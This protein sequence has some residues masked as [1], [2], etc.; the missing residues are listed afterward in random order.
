MSRDFYRTLD[1]FI[2]RCENFRFLLIEPPHDSPSNGIEL[3]FLRN[4]TTIQ[5]RDFDNVPTSDFAGAID[6][7]IAKSSAQNEPSSVT[8][9]LDDPYGGLAPAKLDKDKKVKEA[10]EMLK[11]QSARH[12]VDAGKKRPRVSLEMPQPSK[13]SKLLVASPEIN[14]ARLLS[15][16]DIL[17]L[18]GYQSGMANI[19]L[20]TEC[21]QMSVLGKSV[22]HATGVLL[23]QLA[24]VLRKYVV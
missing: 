23:V 1:Q 15:P 13:S 7:K 22:P 2:E 5:T 19:T 6:K 18:L 10:A 11:E 4:C 16:N 12:F 9:S 14:G 3:E 24:T 17:K 20:L 8:L 21:Q